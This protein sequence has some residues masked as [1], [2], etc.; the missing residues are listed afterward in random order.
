MNLGHKN[1]LVSVI[2]PAFNAAAFIEETVRSAMEQTYRDIEIIVIDDGSPDNLGEIVLR[3]QNEDDRI[4]YEKK[5]NGGVSSARNLGYEMAKGYYFSFLDADDTWAANRIEKIM[6]EFELG[7]EE[8]GLVHTDMRFMDEKSN[9]L[10]G[11]NRGLSG[12]VLDDLLIWERCVIPAPGS[13]IIKKEV[14]EEI[15]LFN[16]KL[17]TAADQEIFIRIASKYEVKRIP[18][19]LGF[20]RILSNSMSRSNIHT[21][22]SDHLETYKVAERLRLFKSREFRDQCFSNLYIILAGTWWKDGG[23]KW[24]GLFFV[25]KSIY[26]WPFNVSKILVKLSS[27]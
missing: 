9:L 8:L 1:K 24:R 10:E 13:C 14:L 18:E 27:R 6:T 7:E 4:T 25:L 12:R 3:L 20:S 23:N 26:T 16:E 5:K 2:I 21:I 19:E 17:S 22:E 11:A 15:G